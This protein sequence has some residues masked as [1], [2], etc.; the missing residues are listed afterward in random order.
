MYRKATKIEEE[1]FKKAVKAA[2]AE[3]PDGGIGTLSEKTLHAVLKRFYEPDASCR[4][5]PVGRFYADIKK[6][7]KIIEIQTRTLFKL[8]AKL[9]EFLQ[10]HDVTV[11]HPI[12]AKKSVSWIEPDGTVGKQ[13]KSPKKGTI[14]DACFELDFIK[15]YI[16]HE[17][18]HLRLVMLDLSEYRYKNGW[19]R[20]KK[21]GSTRCDM[22]PNDVLGQYYLQSPADYADFIPDGLN[23]TFTSADYAKAAKIR[24]ERVNTELRILLCAGV[25]ER[26]GKVKNAYVYKLVL[27]NGR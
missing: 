22:I 13:H 11:V 21:R 15:D 12:A 20:S 19:D 8:R 27:Q 9:D 4:E 1:R 16:A 26:I 25:I 23:E 6:E 17:N 24:R 10:D 3:A 18:F 2:T 7:N 5:I 14:H